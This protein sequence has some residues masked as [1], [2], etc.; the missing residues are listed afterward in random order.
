MFPGH[1]ETLRTVFGCLCSLPSVK[2]LDEGGCFFEEWKGVHWSAKINTRHHIHS[3][4]F[5]YVCHVLN[6]RLL[7]DLIFYGVILHCLNEW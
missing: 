6:S 7:G 1:R 2:D 5:E 3:K 4:M